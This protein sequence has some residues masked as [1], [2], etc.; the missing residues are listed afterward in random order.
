MMRGGSSYHLRSRTNGARSRGLRLGNH[1][2]DAVILV[3]DGDSTE[4]FAE[5]GGGGRRDHAFRETA[6]TSTHRAGGELL[7]ISLRET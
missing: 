7:A 2:F 5:S 6:K 1:L 3:L 4:A